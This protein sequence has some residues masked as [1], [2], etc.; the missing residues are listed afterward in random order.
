MITQIDVHD[1]LVQ[2]GHGRPDLVTRPTGRAVRSS[3]ETEL[4]RLSGRVLIVLDFSEI[5]IIDCSCADEIV[6]KLVQATLSG[7]I[8]LDALFLLKGLHEDQVSEIEHVLRPRRLALFAEVDG[9]LRMIG[10]ADD[11]VRAN[12]HHVL[13]DAGWQ[14]PPTA[15]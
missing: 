12:F 3:I 15:A 5:R 10:D 13:R 4:A 6:A 11:D 14:L 2:L 8:P 7:E 9:Q 1:V